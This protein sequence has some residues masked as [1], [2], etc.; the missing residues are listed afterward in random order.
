MVPYQKQG[1]ISKYHDIRIFKFRRYSVGGVKVP[2]SKKHHP[3]SLK[4]YFSIRLY[5]L[6]TS[7]LLLGNKKGNSRVK[8]GKTGIKRLDKVNERFNTPGYVEKTRIGLN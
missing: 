1:V 3:F 2:P 6:P 5:F 7:L 4:L 8:D